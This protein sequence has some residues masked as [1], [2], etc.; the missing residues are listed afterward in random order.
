[1]RNTVAYMAAGLIPNLVNLFILPVY[2]RFVDPGE[3]GLV[4]L[5]V[6][7]TTFLGAFMG[8]QLT[9]SI[10][11]LYFDYEGE[12]RRVYCSTMIL[13]I[14]LVNVLLLLPLHLAGPWLA[15]TLFPKIDLPYRPLLL[16]GF[17]FMFFQNLVNYGN[18]MLRVQERGRALLGSALIHT[19]ASVGLG[20]YLVVGRGLGAAGLLAGMA[21]ASAV[22]ALT[23]GW[24]VRAQISLS[25]RASMFRQAAVYSI[26]IIPHSLGGIL[27]MYTGKYVASHFV[28]VAS[29]GLYEFADKLAMVFKLLEQ[30]FHHAIGPT[31]MRE[32][33]ADRAA[34]R[35]RFAGIVTRWAALYSLL[36]LAMALL[37]KE[38]IVLVL[39]PAYRDCYAF[40]PVLMTGYLF[41]GLYGFAANALLFEKKTHWIPAISLT[42]GLLS[43]GLNL[44][45]LPRIGM[46]AVA[47]TTLAAFAVTFVM[48]V[49]FGRR[50]YPLRF[51]W[52]M[53]G[54][55][56]GGAL[57]CLL[58]GMQIDT[59]SLPLDV[60]A[61]L[62][63]VAAFA[64][65]IAWLDPGALRAWLR[66]WWPARRKV[67]SDE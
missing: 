30:S 67:M 28:S 15:R 53:L 34:A 50:V 3:Y 11:R 37:F 65:W 24:L 10:H 13:S 63:L 58:V 19:A 31:F 18:A 48:A 8:L 16:L 32:S 6:T 57:A 2:T 59:S 12:E 17:L 29:I 39:A 51:E 38:A 40:V 36:F 56:F 5:V 26:P 21:G 25:F 33:K 43:V 44:V 27:F 20:L 14:L 66:E 23:H 1:M 47:W 60:L 46:I 4:A 49:V 35:E 64:G 62:V 9:N 54:R 42:A 45:L 55:I 22:H 41:Q 7:T 52:A 61:K